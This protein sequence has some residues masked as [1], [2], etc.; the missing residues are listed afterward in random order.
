MAR[1]IRNWWPTVLVLYVATGACAK[2]SS[3]DST[4]SKGSSVPAAS[5]VAIAKAAPGA[6]AGATA[7]TTAWSG[8]YTA[9]VGAVEPPKN[10]N[11]KAWTLDP[12]SAAIGKGSIDLSVRERGEARGETKGPLGEMTISG[13]YDGKEL[14]ANLL[15]KEP[16]SD[17]AMT[18]F[19]LL[20][21][22]GEAMKGILRVSSRDARIVRE[23]AV[24][25]AKKA[26][27][28]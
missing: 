28:P 7:Q 24:E 5:S 17:G 18:G 15:P 9:K 8:S 10:A 21:T 19:L 14:R 3:T 26:A 27:M 22:E 4:A 1:R 6:S 16:R 12:G 13:L 2:T 11:E 23:A 25:L 20:T